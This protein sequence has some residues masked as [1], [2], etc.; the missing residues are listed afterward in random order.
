MLYNLGQTAVP[1]DDLGVHT[2][3]VEN[4]SVQRLLQEK[5]I[6]ARPIVPVSSDGE[7]PAILN[8]AYT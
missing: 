4:G 6:N 3:C 7:S 5:Q 1:T 8:I 2:I